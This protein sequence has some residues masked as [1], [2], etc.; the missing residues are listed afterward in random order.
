MG[1]GG[2]DSDYPGV[3][4]GRPRFP[5]CRRRGWGLQNRLF[6][7]RGRRPA[8]LSGRQQLA[9]SN[10]ELGFPQLGDIPRLWCYHLIPR[11]RGDS[12][13]RSCIN[14]L[15]LLGRRHE[16]RA[17][18]RGFDYFRRPSKHLHC[19]HHRMDPVGGLRI[20]GLRGRRGFLLCFVRRRLY[21]GQENL[22]LGKWKPGPDGKLWKYRAQH[23]RFFKPRSL[24]VGTGPS[25]IPFRQ[26]NPGFKPLRRGPDLNRLLRKVRVRPIERGAREVL[27]LQQQWTAGARKHLHRL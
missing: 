14:S 7:R 11:P 26:R 6:R 27:G 22:M 5:D 13:L 18:Q 12:R 3:R 15:A 2:L 19:F 24:G 1:W 4:L 10:G 16:W 9:H 21:W 8:V 17:G 20:H 23:S 25:W